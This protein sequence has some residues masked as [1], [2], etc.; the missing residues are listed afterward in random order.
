MKR[1]HSFLPPFLLHTTTYKQF[2]SHHSKILLN[3]K[4]DDDKLVA[5]NNTKIIKFLVF[6]NAL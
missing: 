4:K 3:A 2:E 1:C 5:T 6:T